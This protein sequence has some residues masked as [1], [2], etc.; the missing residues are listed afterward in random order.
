MSLEGGSKGEDKGRK[1]RE[2]QEWA[3]SSTVL[4]NSDTSGQRTVRPTEFRGQGGLACTLYYQSPSRGVSNFLASLGHTGRRR[5]VLGHTLN[6]QTLTKTEEHKK[7]FKYIYDFVLGL[8]QSYPGPH[9]A[10]RL[11]VGHPCES[12][13]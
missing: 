3:L 5:V 9:A 6:T 13:A 8:I 7:G 4:L 12:E 2:A 1:G 10:H 11:W